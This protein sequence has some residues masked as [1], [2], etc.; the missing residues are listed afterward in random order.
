M[1]GVVGE[2][3]AAEMTTKAGGEMSHRV[4][5]GIPTGE[6]TMTGIVIGNPIEMKR[7]H[8]RGP[9]IGISIVTGKPRPAG[10]GIGRESARGVEVQRDIV[11]KRDTGAVKGKE[12]TGDIDRE[13]SL[14]ARLNFF[15]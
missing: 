6:S 14:S 4:A 15:F 8:D 11:A 13:A 9:E 10:I 2:G 7:E 1:I 3:T 12:V 5:R